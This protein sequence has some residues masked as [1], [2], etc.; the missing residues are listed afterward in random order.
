MPSMLYRQIVLYICKPERQQKGR[1]CNSIVYIFYV[2]WSRILG[3]LWKYTFL[4]H[5]T[6]WA[7]YGRSLLVHRKYETERHERPSKR[8]PGVYGHFLHSNVNKKVKYSLWKGLRLSH[9]GN[10]WVALTYKAFSPV[11]LI[12]LVWI[13]DVG[14]KTAISA[15]YRLKQPSMLCTMTS[16]FLFIYL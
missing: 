16:R 5:W 9:L 13:L 11:L 12:F 8:C 3:P 7:L 15:K 2:F 10:P 1:K 6:T 4:H 14:E